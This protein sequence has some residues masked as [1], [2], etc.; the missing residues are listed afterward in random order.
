MWGKSSEIGRLIALRHAAASA[1]AEG[2]LEKEIRLELTISCPTDQLARVGDLDNF[3]TG[4]CDGL[5][6]CSHRT[7]LDHEWSK[8]ELCAIHPSRPI[9][10]VDDREVVEIIARKVAND[11]QV[12][13]YRIA[14]VG[15]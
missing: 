11:E 13:L 10:I 3:V 8:P 6:A 7:A 12:V 1:A 4:V 2:P 9:A 5:M 15:Q 14:L